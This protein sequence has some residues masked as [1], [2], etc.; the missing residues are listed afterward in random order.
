MAIPRISRASVRLESECIPESVPLVIGAIRVIEDQ[1]TTLRPYNARYTGDP[2]SIFQKR[3]TEMIT[4]VSLVLLGSGPPAGRGESR[5]VR[6]VLDGHPRQYKSCPLTPRAAEA[7]VCRTA[8]PSAATAPARPRRCRPS[9][10]AWHRHRTWAGTRPLCR[11]RPW[12]SVAGRRFP[13]PR[14]RPG[15][16][17]LYVR[18]H[19]DTSTHR[20]TLIRDVTRTKTAPRARFRSQGAVSAGG[21][22]CWVRTNVG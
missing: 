5:S 16:R 21:S 6:A 19:R 3:Y 1:I 17:P 18:G 4:R 12:P 9:G 10:G 22:R 7:T 15:R 13:R 20:H 14:N 11:G 8:R 2:R